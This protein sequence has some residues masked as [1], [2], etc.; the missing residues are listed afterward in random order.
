MRV[1]AT[2]RC[3]LRHCGDV[4][5]PTANKYVCGVTFDENW[6]RGVWMVL[7]FGLPSCYEHS[8]RNI[9]TGIL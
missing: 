7:D 8:L 1:N 6:S 2:R 5:G 3:K 4:C 9:N